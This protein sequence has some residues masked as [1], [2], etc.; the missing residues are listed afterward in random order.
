MSY[1]QFTRIFL[2]GMKVPNT[3]IYEKAKA[4]RLLKVHI[5]YESWQM[6]ISK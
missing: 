6:K 4:V 3:K 1:E 2:K 5:I